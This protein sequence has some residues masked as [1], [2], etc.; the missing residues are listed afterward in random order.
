MKKVLLLTGALMIVASAAFAQSGINL[1]WDD[2]TLG[3][4]ASD[5]VDACTQNFGAPNKLIISIGGPDIINDV[6]GAQGVVDVQTTA[7]VLP[8]YWRLDAAGCRQGKLAA[9]VFVGSSN[10]PFSC[11]EPWSQVGQTAGSAAFLPGVNGVDRGR[12]SWIMAVPGVVQIDGT[13]IAPDWY[14]IALNFTKASTTT[15]AGCVIPACIVANEIR[16]TKPPGTPGGDVFLNGPAAA[17]HV[18]WQGGAGTNCP[19]ATPTQS[20]SWGAVKSLYR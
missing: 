11:P 17:Q 2:C 6:N 4:A 1:H 15:C 7:P 14:I 13:N 16:L 9:D 8:D 5:K 18:T 3:A 19:Q 10:A 20:S 12:I